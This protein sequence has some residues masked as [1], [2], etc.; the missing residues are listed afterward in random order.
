MRYKVKDIG[1][2]GLEIRLPITASWLETECPDAGIR[3]GGAGLRMTGR[4]D[5]SGDAYLLRADVRGE[6][7]A[8]CAR[9][10]EP[11]SLALD[12]PVV[13]SYVERDER[14]AAGDDDEEA[15]DD[16]ELVAFSGGVIDVGR[17]VRDEILL[18]LPISP[19]CR[20]DCAGLCP[21]C[22]GNRNERPCDCE[23]RRLRAQSKFAL[24]EKL[25]S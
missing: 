18:A 25:K 15:S 16:G 7:V 14:E 20:A 12:L 10:L 24:L 22:G 1:D 3:P 5:R 11:A 19:L 8:G 23:E 21:V 17:E 4:L 13:V 9:C 6:V 2:E